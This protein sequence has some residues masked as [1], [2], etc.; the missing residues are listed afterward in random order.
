[1]WLHLLCRAEVA[2]TKGVSSAASMGCVGMQ[3]QHPS[4]QHK[5][6]TGKFKN[7]M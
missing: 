3:E 4:L 1:M 7:V 6:N 2:N 5:E